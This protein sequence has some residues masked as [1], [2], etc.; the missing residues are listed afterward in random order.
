MKKN[1]GAVDKTVRLILAAVLVIIFLKA[2]VTGILG[3]ALLAVA[4][5]LVLTSIFGV[6]PLY[7]LLGIKSCTTKKI[8]NG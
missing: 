3:L 2:V 8:T 4:L 5:V 6:C 1:V 7:T